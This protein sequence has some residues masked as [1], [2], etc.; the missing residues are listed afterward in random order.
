[1]VLSDKAELVEETSGRMI[2]FTPIYK[3]TLHAFAQEKGASIT[4]ADVK[5]IFQKVSF[6]LLL[7]LF[8]CCFV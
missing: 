4:E 1:M 8:I 7:F 3:K 6:L 5:P 2:L